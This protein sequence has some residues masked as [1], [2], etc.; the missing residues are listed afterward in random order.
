MVTLKY[1]QYAEI[2]QKIKGSP[3][4]KVLTIQHEVKEEQKQKIF[5]ELV[6]F[7]GVWQKRSW[8]NHGLSEEEVRASASNSSTDCYEGPCVSIHPT[9]L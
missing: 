6:G 7:G 1:V 5:W 4:G 3:L 8:R 9:T 2:K